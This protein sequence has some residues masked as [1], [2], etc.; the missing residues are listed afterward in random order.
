M[1]DQGS[2]FVPSAI[3]VQQAKHVI[4]PFHVRFIT[5]LDVRVS[6]LKLGHDDINMLSVYSMSGPLQ[7][8]MFGEV[9]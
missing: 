5:G 1:R 9:Y 3:H 6:V 8:W 7:A 2:I 4:C